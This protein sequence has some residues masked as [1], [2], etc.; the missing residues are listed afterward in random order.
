MFKNNKALCQLSVLITIKVNWKQGSESDYNISISYHEIICCE[1]IFGESSK[2]IQRIC[3]RFKIS[4]LLYCATSFD[5]SEIIFQW[6][7]HVHKICKPGP[8]PLCSSCHNSRT[9]VLKLVLAT[10]NYFIGKVV[11]LFF[12]SDFILS[13]C[14]IYKFV[15]VR[16]DFCRVS[17]L[18]CL[19]C[20]LT[21]LSGIGSRGVSQESV[22]PR[23][24]DIVYPNECYSNWLMGNLQRVLGE[25]AKE[26]GLL[27]LP[28][29]QVLLVFFVLFS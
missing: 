13:H 10:L 7:R 8:T 6:W 2:D 11:L 3:L 4:P 19:V 20:A 18:L 15:S 12:D 29:G 17:L 5:F 16:L 26:G 23:S 14:N 28:S 22:T 25:E 24:N 27:H 9:F 21:S 1:I